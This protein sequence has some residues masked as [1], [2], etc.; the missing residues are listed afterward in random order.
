[1]LGSSTVL[2]AVGELTVTMV[3]R[4]VAKPSHGVA[5]QAG[6]HGSERTYTS[7]SLSP[8]ATNSNVSDNLRLSWERPND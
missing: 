4:L 8:S 1:M 6:R 5:W 7:A 2:V 3:G